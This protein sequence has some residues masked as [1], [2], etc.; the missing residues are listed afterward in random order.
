[1]LYFAKRANI[2]MQ[3]CHTYDVQ[4]TYSKQWNVCQHEV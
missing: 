3:C 2:K 1:M 4:Q